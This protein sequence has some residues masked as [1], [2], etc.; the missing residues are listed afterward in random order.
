MLEQYNNDIEVAASR[1]YDSREESGDVIISNIVLNLCKIFKRLY[2][3]TLFYARFA[4]F[5]GEAPKGPALVQPLLA[6]C[7]SNVEGGVRLFS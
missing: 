1:K 5:A 2:I 4:L 6:R 3:V 7:K